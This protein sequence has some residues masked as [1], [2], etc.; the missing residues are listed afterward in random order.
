MSTAFCHC[1]STFL[2]ARFLF[3]PLYLKRGLGA[4]IG[5]HITMNASAQLLREIFSP[6]RISDKD[7]SSW[8]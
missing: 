2:F 6:A 8:K 5:A 1:T 7:E 3:N 4:S